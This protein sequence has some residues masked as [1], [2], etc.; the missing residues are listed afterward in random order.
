[1]SVNGYNTVEEWN[2]AQTLM[3]RGL[4]EHYSKALNVSVN[5]IAETT[6]VG[7]ERLSS[8]MNNTLS[9]LNPTELD[10]IFGLVGDLSRAEKEVIDYHE[11]HGQQ[12]PG[13]TYQNVIRDV[14]FQTG[15][16]K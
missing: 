9:K 1:M 14:I 16:E 4:I 8:F 13:T 3:V 5:E 15:G 11:A 6:G 7:R 2:H 10:S 12:A